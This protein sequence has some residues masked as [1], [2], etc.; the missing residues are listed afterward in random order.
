MSF[1]VETPI[2][3]TPFEPPAEHWFLRPGHP[4]ERRVGR[5]PALVFQPRDQA[6]PW[7]IEGD[8]TLGPLPEYE[9]AYGLTLVNLLRG[10]LAK[11]QAEGRPG[12][13]RVTRELIDWWRRD[14]RQQRLFFAQLEAAETMIFLREARPDYLQ[15]IS[16]PRDEPGEEWRERGYTGFLRYAC[17]MATGGGKTTVM[18]MVAAWS[19]LNK[20]QDRTNATYSDVVL[21]VCPNITIRSRLLELDPARGD[22]SLYRSR[23]LVPVHLMPL[24]AR[25]RV[26]ITNWHVFEPQMANAG[27]VSAR[28]VKAGVRQTTQETIRI[29]EKTTTARGLRYMTPQAL[30]A[31]TAAGSLRV[32]SE[33]RDPAGHITAV[34]V[35]RERWVE[36]DTAIVTRVLGR[37]IGGKQNILVMNDEAHHAYR[38]RRDEGGDEELYEGEEEDE[39]Y[40]EATVWVEGLDRVNKLRGINFCLDLS[41][42]PYFLGRVGRM[43]GR[44][45]PWVV[46]EFG[47]IDAIE[48]GLVKIPQ[49]ALGDTSGQERPDYFNIWDWIVTKKLTPAEKG[50][51]KGSPKPE[52]ILKYA[53]APIALL[54]GQWQKDF[55]RRQAEDDADPRP[56][57]FIIVCKNT[58][59]AK[60]VYEWLAE[61]QRPAGIPAAGLPE[62]LNKDGEV[63]T[64]RVDTKVVHDTDRGQSSESGSKADEQRWMRFTLD[65]VG[66]TDWTRDGQGRAIYPEGFEELAQKLERPFHPP[67]RDVRCIVSVAMLTEGWDANTVSHIVGLRPFMSQLL[68]EQVVGRGLR[69]R[70]YDLG[71]NDRFGEEVAQV[72]GV[73]FEVIPFKAPPNGTTPPLKERHRVHAVTAKSEYEITF[74]RVERYTQRV[75]GRVTV[76]WE[77]VAPLEINPAKIPP[78]VE[79]SASL[80][81]NAGRPSVLIPGRGMEATLKQFRAGKRLQQLVFAMAR[82]LTQDMVQNGD[83]AVPAGVL[84][85]QLVQVVQRYV[86]DRV[87]VVPPS[88][89]LDLFLSPYYGWTIE[90]LREAIRPDGAAGEGPELPVYERGARRVGSTAQ[91]DAWTSKPVIEVVKSHVNL[92]VAHTASWEQQVAQRLDR[93]PAV[94][95]FVKNEFLEFA[96]PYVDNGQSHDYYPDFLVRLAEQPRCTVILEVKG[97]PDPVEQVKGAAARRWC[98]AINAEGSFGWWGYAIIRDPKE[99]AAVLEAMV[100]EA[101]RSVPDLTA[102]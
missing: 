92:M 15:G 4:P 49:L 77:E 30:D 65:T 93:H 79:L 27:D 62:F 85:P 80:P 83:V 81:N 1:E 37:E 99:T 7:D 44:P 72:L 74:P 26:V 22:A 96:I 6:D 32:L 66:K 11:W 13:T 35:E 28:V 95:A 12:A 17:K 94:R 91:I 87:F 19:I 57:V 10:Q 2:L 71:E 29:A 69:R 75:T 46:S 38:I 97:R 36:S 40:R 45:F 52:A 3:N 84:F 54:A 31:L 56:P 14:G 68:C 23:D 73:P 41:A 61:D 70:R 98:S 5:R 39:F 55:Q 8:P 78:E 67:G 21:V 76:Q 101:Q 25:G 51:K 33:R 34:V 89:R 58:A 63:N 102:G 59:I 24:L 48:S 53:H 90:R 20:V 50:G 88:D 18:A 47:L 42:T 100:G 82:D 60:V 43:T 16:I 9:R 64:I 86:D